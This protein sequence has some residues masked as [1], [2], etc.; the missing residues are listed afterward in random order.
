MLGRSRFG[1][2]R[3]RLTRLDLRQFR[4]FDAVRFEPAAGISL[5]TGANGAGKT[6]VLEALHLLAYG[7]SFRGRVRDGLIREGHGALEVFAEW[8]EPGAATETRR[9]GLRHEG[10]R[11]LGRLDGSD[12]EQLGTLCQALAVVTFEPGSHALVAGAAEGRRRFLD[13]GLFHVEHDSLV[14]WRRYNRALRQRNALLKSGRAGAD[15][16]AWDRELHDAAM[17]LD[18]MRERYAEAL[19]PYVA[20]SAAELVP[21]IGPIDLRYAP[22]WRRTEL[23][24]S[25]ALL[26]ARDRDRGSGFTS[27]GPHRA[28][29]HIEF[30]QFPGRA[31]L[32]R[33]Q[34]KLLALS[35]LLGQAAHLASARGGWPIVALDDM[36]SELDHQH[37]NLLVERLV[38]ANAQV[39]MTGTDIPAAVRSRTSSVAVFH[40]E[41]GTIRAADA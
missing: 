15:L 9:I 32:S 29:M 11:W 16:D 12:V 33:G 38:R 13:W 41:H 14:P 28:E 3:V 17:P 8:V 19:A 34:G 26:L 27:V 30:D 22:G 37:Q 2:S 23:T 40:V 35:L 4:R 6:S 24:L 25:D 5:L 21:G 10:A 1:V 7:R 20:A 31:A 39:L 36:A 18:Q